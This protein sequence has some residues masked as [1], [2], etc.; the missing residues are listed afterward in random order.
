MQIKA[1]EMIKLCNIKRKEIILSAIYEIE[2]RFSFE[3]ET[4]IYTQFSF[5]NKCLTKDVKW[6]TDHYGIRLF[7]KDIILRMNYM[8]INGKRVISLGYKTPDV[9]S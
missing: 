8:I 9:G 3:S 1:D 2:T 5:L 7:K 4:D 6:K